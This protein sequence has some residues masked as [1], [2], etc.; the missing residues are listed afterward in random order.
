MEITRVQPGPLLDGFYAAYADAYRHDPGPSLTPGYFAWR[1]T[2][3]FTDRHREA[4][5]GVEDGEVIAGYLIELPLKDNTHRGDLDP[6]VV[7]PAHR[8]RGLGTAL[9]HHAVTRLRAHGRELLIAEAEATGSAAAFAGARGLTVSLLR[10]RSSLDLRTTDW[11]ALRAVLP[12]VDGYR[13][14]RWTGPASPELLPDLTALMDGMNDAPGAASVWDVDRI[15]AQEATIPASGL[16]VYAMLARRISDGA[17]AGFT[18]VFLDKDGQQQGWAVQG[19][20]AV[21]RGHRGHR[22]GLLLKLNTL[23][24]LHEQRPDIERILA[25]NAASNT[26]MRA[27]NEILGYRPLDTWNNWRLSV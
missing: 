3:G 21:L 14:E 16:Q 9:L 23:F 19:E 8:R 24:W 27:I 7:R 13:L 17:V 5:A 26:R 11:A 6:L 10:T 15:R 2:E 18:R 22:L 25:W 4:W 20:T 12:Q 1:I